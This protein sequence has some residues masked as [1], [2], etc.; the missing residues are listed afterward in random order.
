VKKGEDR[1]N[2]VRKT[3]RQATHSHRHS[4]PQP[5]STPAPTSQVFEL[6]QLGRDTTPQANP[7]RIDLVEPHYVAD[8]SGQ[9][10]SDLRSL[11]DLA[12]LLGER[13]QASGA[14]AQVCGA[15]GLQIVLEGLVHG[16]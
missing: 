3:L 15:V 11:V 8:L 4:A 1:E 14:A 16:H 6:P 12:D 2:Q 9:V 7:A 13:A 5:E 10:S